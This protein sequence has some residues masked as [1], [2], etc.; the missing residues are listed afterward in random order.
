M[1]GNDRTAGSIPVW[2]SADS[3]KSSVSETL[4]TA[5]RPGQN[6][7]FREVLAYA[8]TEPAENPAAPGE[9]FG[10]G[11]IIDMINPLQHIP[12]VG[13]IYRSLTGDEIKPV[14]RIIGGA[15]FGGPIGAAGGIADAIVENETGHDITDN[16]F[17]FLDGSDLPPKPPSIPNQDNPELRLARAEQTLSGD[18]PGNLLSFVDMRA[19][20]GIT[21]EKLDDA[22][23]RPYPRLE[24]HKDE[25]REAITQLFLTNSSV[26]EIY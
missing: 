17:A 15:V 8:Q 19:G 20:S 22:K 13:H 18:M 16:A 12:V 14:S 9:E 7:D 11:D 24:D 2:E 4:G 21:I 10:F 5:V 3:A 6:S 1:A 26:Y 23:P 25:K